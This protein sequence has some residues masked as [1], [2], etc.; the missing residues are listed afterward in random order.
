VAADVRRAPARLAL[1]LSLAGLLGG[2]ARAADLVAEQITEQS[3]AQREI[4][5]PDAIGGVGDWY[6]AND[7]IE[8]VIDDV[9]REFGVI[10]HGGTLVDVGLRDR[11]GDDQLAR[12]SPMVNLA[13]RVVVGYDQ[14]HAAVDPKGAF[15]NVTVTS[16]GLRA[17]PRGS[18]WARLFDFL[19]P[20]PGSVS[21]VR[22]ETVYEV[23]PGEPFVRIETTLTN[24]GSATAPVFAFGDLWMRGGRGGRGFL[25]D[26]AAPE[27]ARGF[28]TREMGPRMSSFGAI[29][30][31][32]H[33]ALVGSVDF[34]AIGY[35]LY[36]PERAARGLPLY[37]MMGEHA[38]LVFGLVG[39]PPVPEIGPASLARAMF[40]GGLAP[41]ASWH[42]QRR[43]RVAGR[44][45]VA[46]LDGAIR[47]EI[48]GAAP[49]S[50]VGGRV[51][52]A[53]RRAVVVIEMPG[54]A[55]V[56]EIG[57][58]PGSGAFRAE[59]PPG[60]YR[61][62]LRVEHAAPQRRTLRVEPARIAELAFD[63]PTSLAVLRFA[64]AFADGGPGRVEIRGRDG[65]SDPLFGDDLLSATLEGAPLESGTSTSA[66][67][68]VGNDRD[69]R[70]VAL[71]PGRYTLTATRGLDWEAASQS[72]DLRGPVARA[73]AAPF[74]LR[75]LEPI[76]GAVI[77]DLHVHSQASDD[78]EA[79]N[80]DRLRRF[81][82][83]GVKVLVATDHD[84]VANYDPALERLALGSRVRVVQG[85]EV[86]GSGPSAAALWTIGHH[87][88]WPIRYLPHAHRHGAPPSQ[89]RT[90]GAIYSALRS[91]H[92]ARVVQ[93]NHPRPT[94]KDVED[95]NEALA[96]FGHLGEG[97][98]FDPLLPLDAP[99]NEPLVRRTGADGTRALDFDAMEVMNGDSWPQYLA[100]RA[101]WYALLRQGVRRTGTANSDSHAA[102]ELVAY[103]RNYVIVG[104][105]GDDSERFDAAL[106]AG[107]SF[108]TNGPRV[109]ELRVNGGSIGDQV[110]A[111]GGRVHI[112]YTVDGA[113]FVPIDEVR[114]LLNGEVAHSARER[115][116]SVDLVLERDGFVTLEAGAPLDADAGAWIRAHPGLFTDAIAPGFVPAMFS[117]PVF[118]DVDGNGRFDPP[119]L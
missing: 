49:E 102:G 52:I 44:R 38:T 40:G 13:Q 57:V 43:L 117:N 16:P 85:V 99:E 72:V 69:P 77:A 51:A 8:L 84:N 98:P 23:R 26:V 35:A 48:A 93:L 28:A 94:P 113:G 53:D 74:V 32:T 83:E 21:A 92:G 71:A 100:M 45:D 78:G 111:P 107:R 80:E 65:T 61:A 60:D 4:G 22:V 54:G 105:D 68:F 12:I 29:A 42:W 81:V 86:T 91:D 20:E 110:A 67:V 41:G 27:R 63:A 89:N 70:E 109:R 114:V 7:V 55:L 73:V 56:T 76:A 97:R 75:P 46:A 11:S 95:G 1:A 96:F 18:R 19:V 31:F 59:L 14:I 108:G 34:P 17:L 118:V 6:L 25:G 87:N 39:D 82:A 116:G 3:A 50:G 58:D 115:S 2:A 119:G 64:P 36:A 15:A 104:A 88:A 33:A 79:T 37:G 47:A 10:T 112:E 90:V 66:V 5:G 106:K 24:T 62:E 30:T 9:S 103:P 101:D